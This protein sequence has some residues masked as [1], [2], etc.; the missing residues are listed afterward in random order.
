MQLALRARDEFLSIAA[1]EIRGPLTSLQ[2]AAESLQEP[3]VSPASSQRMLEVVVRE[4]GRLVRFVDDLSDLGRIRTGGLRIELEDVNLADVVRD[5]AAR[6]E[7]AI[8]RSGS[9]LTVRADPSSVGCWDRLRLEQIVTN[10]LN[11]ALKFG[12]AKPIEIEV[13]ST[14]ERTQMIVTD[15]GIGVPADQRDHIFEPFGRAVSA[16]NY[17]GLG[18]G[19]FIVR[20]LVARFGGSVRLE[21]GPGSGSRFVVELPR[22]RCS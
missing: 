11:N 14:A 4:I 22:T 5:V 15:Q 7:T 19:L 13:T 21:A 9:T 8:T 12:L 18:L 10:L 2:L 3:E 6:L 1:H 16:R 20:N 17:G